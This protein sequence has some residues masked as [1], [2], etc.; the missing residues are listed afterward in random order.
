V[1]IQRSATA[2]QAPRLGV[3]SRAGLEAA[4]S[5]D[6]IPGPD[7]DGEGAGTSAQNSVGAT[8]ERLETWDHAAMTDPD[9]G[10]G[11][12][13]QHWFMTVTYQLIYRN[14]TGL[15]EYTQRL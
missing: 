6:L 4:D 9:E 8:V 14:S 7:A 1:R 13:R 3:R 10:A 5:A 11:E 2:T 15:L 12:E